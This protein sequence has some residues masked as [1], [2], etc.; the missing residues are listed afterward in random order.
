M[1]RMAVAAA[2]LCALPLPA[3]GQEAAD[4]PNLVL[5]SSAEIGRSSSVN[6]GFKRAL[7]GTLGTSG[8]VLMGSA[9]TGRLQDRVALETH[10]AQID[11]LSTQGS[12]LAGYQWA[13]ERAM[14]TLLAGPEADYRH[15]LTDGALTSRSRPHFGARLQAEIWA[16]PTDTTLATGTLIVGTALPHLWVRG[17]WGYRVWRDIHL[18]PEAT[19]TMEEDY[20]EARLGLHATGIRIGRYHL[21]LSGGAVLA[22]EG[23]PSGYLALTTFYRM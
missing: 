16:H 12:L 5:F 1:G 10:L 23:R 14:I 6:S 8:F 19:V 4:E 7:G 13:T 11:Y 18:G 2:L 17:S 21:R 20:R 9:G 15:V 22:E 3:L